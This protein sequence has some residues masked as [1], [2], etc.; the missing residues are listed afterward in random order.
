MSEPGKKTDPRILAG[1]LV[2]P[3]A[4]YIWY[5]VRN[6]HW[7]IITIMAAMVLAHVAVAIWSLI[8]SRGE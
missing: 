7:G 3:S 8:P 1:M 4:F 5:A 6:P 2:P